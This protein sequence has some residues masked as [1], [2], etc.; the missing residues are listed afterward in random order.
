MACG[1][2]VVYSHMQMKAQLHSLLAL[3]AIWHQDN[4]YVRNEN[5]GAPTGILKIL[6][7]DMGN[8]LNDAA[9]VIGQR[10]RSLL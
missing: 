5:Q 4:S 8:A 7:G 1:I 10:A 3:C 6:H 2:Y 9:A